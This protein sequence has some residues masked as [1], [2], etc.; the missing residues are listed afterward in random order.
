MSMCSSK[1][2]FEEAKTNY[3]YQ[4]NRFTLWAQG[5]PT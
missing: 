3:I 5:V 4:Q 2:F 1:I